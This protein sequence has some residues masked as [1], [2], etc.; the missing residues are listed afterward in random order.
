MVVAITRRANRR[1]AGGATVELDRP[2]GIA[3][4]SQIERA[5]QELHHLAAKIPPSP[6]Q[7]QEHVEPSTTHHD[8]GTECAGREPKRDCAGTEH[9]PA[10]G[11]QNPTLELDAGTGAATSGES[12]TAPPADPGVAECLQGES[13]AG[14]GGS[15]GQR[16]EAV[17][18]DPDRLLPPPWDRATAGGG[19]GPLRVSAGRGDAT[20]HLPARGGT[21]WQRRKVQTASAVLAYSRMLFFQMY[22]SFQ[23]FDC[24]VFLTEA[25]RYFH[26]APQRAMIDNT[27]VVVL[28]G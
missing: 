3:A 10:D 6:V 20:R 13:G 8:S 12:R 17:V 25:L 1:L 22:P 5:R 21:V 27:H 23:R 15:G 26:G 7:E 18:L 11:T 14:A 9:Q 4:H 24:K 19:G 16:S 28:R 2:Q